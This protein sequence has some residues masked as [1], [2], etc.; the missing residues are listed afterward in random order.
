MTDAPDFY[1]ILKIN[2]D[3]T[4]DEVSRAYR[5]LL[6]RHH[7]DT[8]AEADTAAAAADAAARLQEVMDAYSVL[9]DPARRIQYDRGRRPRGTAPI[10][11]RPTRQGSAGPAPL[12]GQ[13][14]IVGP[15]QWEPPPGRRN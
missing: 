8:R 10:L 11:Q 1:A 6:R 9:G 4:A 7:P 13:P 15:L 2:P 14:L 5:S 12:R 3:A